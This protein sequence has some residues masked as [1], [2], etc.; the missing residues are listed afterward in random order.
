MIRGD[1]SEIRA[2]ANDLSEI[3]ARSIP[4]ARAGMAVAGKAAERAW[5]ND[6]ARTH[7]SHAKFYADS[8]DSELVF[9]VASAAVEIGPN[10]AKKQ[11][12]LGKILEFGGERSPAYLTGLN[13][14]TRSEPA[15][16]RALT[17]AMDPL[18][19]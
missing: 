10:S 11:G 14:I 2:L 1:A 8:I 5:R 13:A 4:A 18:F 7:D 17:Q 12:F 9:S 3:G 16:E 19:R 15:A 6:A